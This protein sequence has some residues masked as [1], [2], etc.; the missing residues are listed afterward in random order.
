MFALFLLI[1]SSLNCQFQLSGY[2]YQNEQS[3]LIDQALLS[4]KRQ[5]AECY[6]IEEFIRPKID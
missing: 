1:C 2:R 3:C 6:P 5:L 4:R